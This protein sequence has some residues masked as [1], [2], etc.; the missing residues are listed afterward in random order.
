MTDANAA[1]PEY[2]QEIQMC[3]FMNRILFYRTGNRK[4]ETVPNI[5]IR[6]L[7]QLNRNHQ[8]ISNDKGFSY[9]YLVKM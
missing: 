2:A 3:I 5:Y 9:Q 1:M 4:K 8:D 7:N 6:F